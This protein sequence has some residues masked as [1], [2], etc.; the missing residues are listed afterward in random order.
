MRCDV[1]FIFSPKESLEINT[2]IE[3]NTENMEKS[4]EW[5]ANKWEELGCEPL[6]PSGKVLLLDR[7]LAITDTLGHD[8]LSEH[9]EQAEELARHFA[10]ALDSMRVVVDLPGLSIHSS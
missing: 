5:I 10:I 9:A 7:V 1:T 4:R 6:R 2:S 3:Y 8:W